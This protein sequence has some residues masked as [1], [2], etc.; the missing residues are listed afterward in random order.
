M[1]EIK[2]QLLGIVLVVT[3]FGVVSAAMIVIFNRLT[4]QTQE[5]VEQYYDSSSQNNGA[6]RISGYLSY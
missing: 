3:L 6:Y 4:Q 2:G 5:K 1:S